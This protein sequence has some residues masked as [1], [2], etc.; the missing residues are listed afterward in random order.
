MCVNLLSG[1][2]FNLVPYQ[3]TKKAVSISVAL[4][5]FCFLPSYPQYYVHHK[6]FQIH[7]MKHF[8]NIDRGYPLLRLSAR[9]FR[10]FWRKKKQERGLMGGVRVGYFLVAAITA[11][12]VKI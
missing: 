7:V 11:E 12:K 5:S 10:E 6:R 4:F 3:P 2:H 9:D 1:C 8:Q